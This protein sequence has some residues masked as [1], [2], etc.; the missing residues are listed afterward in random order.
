M[1]PF[2]LATVWH[3]FFGTLLFL[4]SVFLILLILVQRGRGGGLTGALGGMGGQSAFGTKAGDLFTRITIGT[5]AVWLLLC[6]ASVKLLTSSASGPFGRAPLTKRENVEKG[7]G[8]G[9]ADSKAPN[10]KAP[11]DKA[12]ADKAPAEKTPAGK[13]PEDQASPG[14]EGEKPAA[15]DKTAPPAED[16]PADKP[17]DAPADKPA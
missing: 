14:Q 5:A 12:P 3:W 2:V 6:M 17:A 15:T 10:D 4:S 9:G 13:T 1:S 7:A 8:T 11:A 16:K